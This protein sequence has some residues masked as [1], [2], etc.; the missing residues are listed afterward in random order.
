MAIKKK[1][2]AWLKKFFDLEKYEFEKILISREVI[3]N[4]VELANQTYPNEFIAFLEGKTKNKILMIKGLLYQEY[5]ANPSYAVYKF[6]PPL[7][8]SIVG[9]VHSHP[10]PSNA[11]SKADLYS[12]SKKGMV[13]LIIKL[14]YSENNIQAYDKNGNKIKFE[15]VS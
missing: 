2:F 8:S 12:F 11:P 14:P 6:D 10:G 3:D 1:F 13:H 9:S 4:I 15:V 7:T 5:I